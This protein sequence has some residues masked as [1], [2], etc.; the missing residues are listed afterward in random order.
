MHKFGRLKLICLAAILTALCP[1]G[2]APAHFGVTA[3]SADYYPLAVGDHWT[4]GFMPGTKKYDADITQKKTINGV[5]GYALSIDQEYSFMAAEP[6]GIYQLAQ[7]EPGDPTSA[8]VFDPPQRIYK[9]P[10]VVGDSWYTPVLLEPSKPKSQI[11]LLYG[12]VKSLDDITVPAGSFK[13]CVHVLIDDPRDSPSDVTEL[14]FA[15]GVGVVKT[16]TY[17]SRDGLAPKT[18]DTELISYKLNG[19]K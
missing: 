8:L 12:A 1:A 2:C 15:A 6:T 9:L 17:I 13:G 3:P 10:F 19:R 7:G 16:R 11:V 14:W 18:Y 4:Y 5:T